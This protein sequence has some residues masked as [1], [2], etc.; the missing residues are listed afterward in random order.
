MWNIKVNNYICNYLS[1]YQIQKKHIERILSAKQI[2]NNKEPYIPKF[3]KLKL[4]RHQMEEEKNN[5]IIEGNKHLFYKIINAEIKPSKYSKIYKPK[6]CPSFNKNII[7]FKRI[8]NEFKKYEENIRF[9]HKIE[10]VKSFYENKNLTQRNKTIDNN[11][12]KLQK[13]ILELQPTLLFLSPKCSK[14]QLHKYSHITYNIPKTKRCNSCHNRQAS[15][16]IVNKKRNK[17]IDNNKNIKIKTKTIKDNNKNNATIN[18]D[19][20]LKRFSF[21]ND[22]LLGH[23]SHDNKEKNKII[24][25]NLNNVKQTI[26]KIKAMEEKNKNT[27]NCKNNE[28]KKNIK[29]INISLSKND[30]DIRKDIINEREREKPKKIKFGLKRNTSEINIFN[31]H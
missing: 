24:E 19:S 18:S 15:N 12:K 16:T 29:E 14:N 30:M 3:L 21:L 22:V 6:K 23:K 1:E 27:K 17:T 5:K 7:S 20:T 26:M 9:Y 13:T 28:N 11:I 2:T 8:K 4:C 31:Q 10:K 25:K